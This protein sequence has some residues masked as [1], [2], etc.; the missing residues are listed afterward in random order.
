MKR[1]LYIVVICLVLLLVALGGWVVEGVRFGLTGS[2]R[3][4]LATA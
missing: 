3:R 4:A 2:R 1:Q